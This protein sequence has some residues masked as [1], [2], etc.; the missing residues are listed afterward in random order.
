MLNLLLLKGFKIVQI[1]WKNI[2]QSKL[3]YFVVQMKL[4]KALRLYLG[5]F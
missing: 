5:N 1:S 4:Y 2:L 3:E